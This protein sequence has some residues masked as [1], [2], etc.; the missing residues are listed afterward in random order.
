[1]LLPGLEEFRFRRLFK[2]LPCGDSC[3]SSHLICN[4]D[5][6]F[7]NSASFRRRASQEYSFFDGLVWIKDPENVVQVVQPAFDI[8]AVELVEVLDLGLRTA[9]VGMVV[10]GVA[11]ESA[12]ESLWR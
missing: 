1:M 2:F 4:A 10:R 6:P 7:L 9:A 11:A 12:R 5:E 8:L 3:A